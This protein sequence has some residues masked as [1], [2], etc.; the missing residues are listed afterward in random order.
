MKT[1]ILGLSLAAIGLAGAAYAAA[2]QGGGDPLGDKTV[3]KAEFIAKH[4]EMF[5]KMDTNRDG[6][7]DAADRAAHMAQRFDGAD[8]DKNGS[9]SRDEFAAAHARG[10][11]GDGAAQDGKRMRHGGGHGMGMKMLGM[12]DT[13]KD[14][15]VTRAEFLTGAGQHFDMMDANKDGS[16]SAAE[17]K[18]ARAKMKGMHRGGRGGHAGHQMGDMAPPPPPA[19]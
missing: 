14:G 16:L 10:P 17:R 8:A 5:D 6:K 1:K 7:L 18:A 13:N 2:P 4:G 9:L 19:N 11:K 3:T 12:V 15:S